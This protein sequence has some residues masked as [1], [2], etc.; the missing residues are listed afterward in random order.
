[1]TRAFDEKARERFAAGKVDWPVL[2]TGPEMK[3]RDLH[4]EQITVGQAR[5]YIATYHYSQT[6]PDATKE[7][8]AGFYDGYIVGIMVFGMGASK[9]IFTRI[10]PRIKNGEYRELTR[11][12]VADSAPKNT[13]TRL[14]A[15]S[16]KSLPPEVRFIVSFSDQ[17]QGHEGTVYRAANFTYDG[18]TNGG[19]GSRLIDEKGHEVHP[20]LL[21]IYKM[22]HPN[23]Y[24]SMDGPA[25][26]KALGWTLTHKDRS[27]K[28]RFIYH[29]YRRGRK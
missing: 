17:A 23:L 3:A 10:D 11:G 8:F 2:P 6:M 9:T 5:P 20:R 16:I 13:N 1:M 12:W 27:T 7:V 15:T 26:A 21:G 22:R 25:I 29:R 4:I 19:V 14:I 18:T 24:G 28:H